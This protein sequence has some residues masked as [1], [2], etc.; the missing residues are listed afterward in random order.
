MIISLVSKL[1][2]MLSRTFKNAIVFSISFSL[3]A[4]A[5]RYS[6]SAFRKASLLL[7]IITSFRL[8]L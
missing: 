3:L 7:F 2:F 5:A 8:A 1:L 6:C 4:W